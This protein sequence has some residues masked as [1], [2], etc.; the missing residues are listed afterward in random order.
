MRAAVVRLSAPTSGEYAGIVMMGRQEVEH[1][2][3]ES[4][5]D[6]HGVVYLP[7]GS[8]SWK[9]AGDRPM[10]AQWSA[11]IVDGVSWTG[12]GK[13]FFNFDLKSSSI[14]Y[15]DT[16]NVIPRPGSARLM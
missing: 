3:E 12:S 6:M 8:I 10:T 5:L 2:F 16:L 14:P 7:K 9:H 11:W 15:P 1:T 13:L 4:H